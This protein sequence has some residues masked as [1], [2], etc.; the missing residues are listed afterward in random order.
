MADRFEEMRLFVTIAD[1]GGFSAAA[2]RCNISKSVASRRMTE[3]EAR[4]G[5]K[6]FHRS[7]RTLSLTETGRL[8]HERARRILADLEAAEACA[9][10]EAQ[11]PRG[12]L[13]IA[14][15]MSFGTMYLAEA[16]S[17]F[18]ADQPNITLALDL[19]DRITD[20]VGGGYDLAIRITDLPDS[21]L[22]ARRIAQSRIVVGAAPA[23]LARHGT[24]KEPADLARHH[25]LGY[26]NR[27][28]SE[29]W[30]FRIEDR[31]VPVPV[32]ILFQANNGEALMLAARAGLGV[33][34]LPSFIVA[35]DLRAGRL[36][37]VLEAFEVPPLDITALYAP[38]ARMP[39]RLRILI[40]FLIAWFGGDFPIWER[41]VRIGNVATS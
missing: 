12:H 37:R 26:S 21:A 25:C 11:E 16:I 3:L 1:T 18:L 14:A 7:T 5:A 10:D 19:D 38:D 39:L 24:P 20:L 17:A 30:R 33:A 36:V 40:D 6:L 31:L 27:T 35:D 2:R 41:G 28:T 34:L 9:M 32:R 23:Y 8:F 29:A 22:I 4:L 15:P 13:R